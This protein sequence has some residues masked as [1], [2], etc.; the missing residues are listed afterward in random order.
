MKQA[1]NYKGSIPRY[2]Y[3]LLFLA[4]IGG[5]SSALNV[6]NIL[7]EGN[8]WAYST[9]SGP[10]VNTV[11]SG[12][13]T[14]GGSE[15]KKVRTEGG[16]DSGEISYFR[17]SDMA[18]AREY[19]P[20]LDGDES[21]RMTLYP[22]MP[23]EYSVS[24]EIHAQKWGGY[25]YDI[26]STSYRKNVTSVTNET[27]TVP[28]GTY[29]TKKYVSTISAS[30]ITVNYTIW[31]N[32]DIGVVKQIIDNDVHVL[33]ATNVLA[34]SETSPRGNVDAYSATNIS[35]WV[36]DPDDTSRAINIHVYVD[37]RMIG[38]TSANLNRADLSSIGLSSTRHG[39]D[40]QIPSPL[41]TGTHTVDVYAINIGSGINKKIGS[42]SIIISPPSPLPVGH[43]DI[44]TD[45]YIQGWAYD[46]ENTS[47][48]VSI[49]I[50][51][52]S[53]YIGSAPANRN[54]PDLS[55][56]GLTNTNHGFN[57][58]LPSSIN[59]GT[60]TIDI[61]AFSDKRIKIGSG[62]ITVQDTHSPIGHIDNISFDSTCGWVYDPDDENRPVL[63]HIYVGDD[64]HGSIEAGVYRSDLSSI[65]LSNTNHG[66][67]F[68]LTRDR[69]PYFGN[70]NM[71]VYAINIDSGSNILIGQGT[72]IVPS[73]NSVSARSITLSTA[74]AQYADGYIHIDPLEV[75]YSNGTSEDYEVMLEGDFSSENTL[76]SALKIE[77]TESKSYSNGNYSDGVLI[78]PS[79]EVR[80]KDE[81]S[82]YR[83]E[84]EL[85]DDTPMTFQLI[86]ADE[87]KPKPEAAL[88]SIE[89][90]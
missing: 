11:S 22:P 81:V 13:V 29:I 12:T 18:L 78:L 33:T 9:N 79:L 68:R 52:D 60:H 46:P 3:L 24:G 63:L 57:I 20:F 47:S 38:D 21:V 90:R 75:L 55:S 35:G 26:G 65:G 86:D 53:E 54:R 27:I 16:E 42:G 4:F 19:Y 6:S 40:F 84:M 67:C 50:Y 44:I 58:S 43:V 72:V 85:V 71:R 49:E 30:G 56:I 36:Y 88:K 48:S 5:Q 15:T 32:D 25:Y 73:T 70:Y 82:T 66:F 10:I 45:T 76:F 74:Q 14:I 23:W 34:A 37:G 31:L 17:T 1:T 28:A 7:Q 41:A 8:Y 80:T 64:L 89:V 62:I 87:V 51:I 83:I 39:F 59:P 61:Y 69:I 2:K 77:K